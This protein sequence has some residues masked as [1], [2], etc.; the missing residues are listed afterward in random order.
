MHEVLGNNPR[1]SQSGITPPQVF[2]EM[3]KTLLSG[4]VWKG[5]LVNRRKD[6]VCIAP[7]RQEDGRITNYVAVKD[8]ITAS[9]EDK[10]EAINT[11]FYYDVLT[12]LPNRRFLLERL[13]HAVAAFGRNHREGALILIDLDNFNRVNDA[14]GHDSG[15]QLLKQV[16]LRLKSCVR[17]SDTIARPGGDEFIVL[18]EDLSDHLHEAASQAQAVCETIL[19]RISAPYSINEVDLTSTASIGISMFSG[20]TGADEVLRRADLAMYRAKSSGRNTMRFFDPEMQEAVTRRA[21]LEAD[22]REALVKERFCCT[23]RP[24][25]RITRSSEQRS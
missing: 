21:L 12:G 7:L 22:L 6:G 19:G 24:R 17:E 5:E 16:A 10:E 4:Q 8:N 1:D 11:L 14:Y 25:S 23:T 18:I 9:K 2:S 15:D 13:Q 20:N 3:W